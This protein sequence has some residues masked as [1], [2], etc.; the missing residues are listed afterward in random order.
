MMPVARNPG[1]ALVYSETPFMVPALY[2]RIVESW[3]LHSLVVFI[4]VRQ[5]PIP[6]VSDQ[7]RLLLSPLEFKGFYRCVARYGYMDKVDQGYL[8]AQSVL[9]KIQQVLPVDSMVAF[10]A[11]AAATTPATAAATV[12]G[13]CD[14]PPRIN[15]SSAGSATAAA[16]AAASKDAADVA[17]LPAKGEILSIIELQGQ[18]D[19]ALIS[20]GTASAAQDGAGTASAA[21]SATVDA[22][23]VA[24][25]AVSPLAANAV[26]VLHR[27]MVVAQPGS[28]CVRTFLL[29]CYV[30][31]WH[32]SSRFWQSWKLPAARL[33]EVGLVTEL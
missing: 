1:M 33:F 8:F 13:D 11:P 7:Q 9:D 30:G 19:S 17:A 6:H 24:I 18:G 31:L 20:A 29:D 28:N 4:T 5:V 26:Y 15:S 2:R 16:A 21:D 10:A 3:G 23:A 22:A 27:A 32:F 25:P 14:M 12:V